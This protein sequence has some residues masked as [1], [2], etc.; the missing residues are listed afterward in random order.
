[1]TDIIDQNLNSSSLAELDTRVSLF[2]EA[3]PNWARMA[4]RRAIGRIGHAAGAPL[5]EIPADGATDRH[6]EF[7]ASLCRSGFAD[8]QRSLSQA[9]ELPQLPADLLQRVR[10]GSPTLADAIYMVDLQSGWGDE[11]GRIKGAIQA[12]TQKMGMLPNRMLAVGHVVEQKLDGFTHADFGIGQR[13]FDNFR[14]RIYR[15]VRL[16]DIHARQRLSRSLLAGPWRVLVDQ[17]DPEPTE[18]SAGKK[19]RSG[20]A[21][22]CAKIW[23]LINYCHRHDIA[24]SEV[25]DAVIAALEL[26][27][28]RQGRADPFE[29]ARDVVYAWERLGRLAPGFPSQTL[30][31]LK[32]PGYNSAHEVM[33]EKL[34]EL[35]RVSWAQYAAKHFSEGGLPKSIAEVVVDEDAALLAIARGERR[36]ATFTR[37]TDAL[38]NFRTVATYAANAALKKGW[39]LTNLR[40]ILTPEILALTLAAVRKRARA[41]AEANGTEASDKSN[42]L[43]NDATIFITMARDLGV[44]V[45]AIAL[46]ED[47][48]DNVDP[49]FLKK[50]RKRD[51]VIKRVSAARKIGPRHAKRLRQFNDPVKLLAWYELPETLYKEA[52]ELIKRQRAIDPNYQPN[53]EEVNSLIVAVVHL[54]TRYCPWRRENIAALRVYGSEAN[55]HLPTRHCSE[56]FLDVDGSEVKNGVCLDGVLPPSVVEVIDFYLRYF[57][58]VLAAAVGADLDNPHLFPAHGMEYR[59]AQ[60]LNKAFVDRNWRRGGFLL[61]LQVQR[62]ICAKVVADEH[63]DKMVLVQRLLG[64]KSIKTTESYYAEI[65]QIVAQRMYHR[66]LDEYIQKLRALPRKAR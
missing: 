3:M 8:E 9:L 59:A 20:T 29:I 1:M 14:G 48:R 32:R 42:T 21:G 62:H 49:H 34:P 50:V 39:L 53:L 38:A 15:A 44:A 19:K 23:P 40:E 10:Q 51:G 13:S 26:D 66:L 43:R 28:E 47:V 11:R 27:L 4:A 33:F 55:L 63:P 41:R 35:F 6:Q 18:P 65:K 46:M 31:R 2:P 45:D 12:F 22:D 64:H 25:D 5:S 61:N 37:K 7:Q 58:P 24:P 16:V 36:D 52:K 56:A 17:V 57:R 60:Q 54:I 30:S